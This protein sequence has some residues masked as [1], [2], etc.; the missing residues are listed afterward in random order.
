MQRFVSTLWNVTIFLKTYASAVKPP[1]RFASGNV[2]DVWMHARLKEVGREVAR[3]MDAY[4]IVEAAR[5][6]NDAVIN[7]L[8]NWYV[9]RSRSRFQRPRDKNEHDEAAESLA[10]FLNE[11]AKLVAP[12]T[13]FLAEAVWQ[14]VNDTKIK[15]VHW[16][17]YPAFA[18]LTVK[19]RTALSAMQRVRT[20]A[21]AHL[22]LR[23]DA[24]IRVRQPLSASA[25]P[26]PL[27]PAAYQSILKD[28]LNVE[29]VVPF[30][31]MEHTTEKGWR[32]NDSAGALNI[33]LSSSLKM[34]GYGRELV[35]AIQDMRR[36]LG[37]K[38]TDRI[39]VS[40]SLSPDSLR[41]KLTKFEETIANDTNADSVREKAAG[42]TRG[43]VRTVALDAQDTVTVAV[44]KA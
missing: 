1:A 38:P 14:D 33:T 37:L 3:E 12:L 15:S 6:L 43:A 10:F 26:G 42:K 8:S 11:F 21:E 23:A 25:I 31:K 4:H 41:G 34:H 27:P 13:P 36:S 9:R 39:R 17:D 32:V 22:R 35:R 30:D 20:M 28:E 2:L 29:N 19:E 5:A 16:E 18:A 7:D 24:H 40:Y 44:D